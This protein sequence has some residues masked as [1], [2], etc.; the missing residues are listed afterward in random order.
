M[1]ASASTVAFADDGYSTGSIH[2]GRAANGD[3]VSCGATEEWQ[4][5]VRPYELTSQLPIYTNPNDDGTVTL[6]VHHN[7]LS[8]HIATAR[9][10]TAEVVGSARGVVEKGVSHWIDF[11]RSVEREFCGGSWCS[12]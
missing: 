6:V 5:Q 12:C 4:S 9:E 8:D 10:A 2:P 11:E 1:V 7:P 3:K